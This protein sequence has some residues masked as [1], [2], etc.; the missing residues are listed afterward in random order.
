MAHAED[1]L[2]RRDFLFVSG[3]TSGALLLQPDPAHAAAAPARTLGP[4]EVPVQV[5]VNGTLHKVKVEP[6]TTLAA[7]LRDRLGLT[8][9]KIGCDRGACGA[10]TVWVD[11]AP[12]PACLTLALDV[13]GLGQGEAAPRPVTTIEGLAKKGALHPVQQAFIDHDAMQCGFCTPGMIMSCAALCERAW[14]AGRTIDET[15]VRQ[16]VAGNLCRCGAYPHIFAATLAAAG[17][18]RGGGR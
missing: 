15:E 12:Q 3:A 16:A 13:A 8:G 5:L 18:G 6:R 9:T 11:G 1:G 7:L 4:G 14:A 2:T 17:R 10:C